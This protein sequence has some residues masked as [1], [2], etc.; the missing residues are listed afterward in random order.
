MRWSYNTIFFF[1]N[2]PQQTPHSSPVRTKYGV[3]VVNTNS[4]LCSASVTR[5]LYTI[6][7]W[8][9]PCY[10]G[11]RLYMKSHHIDQTI[12]KLTYFQNSECFTPK[13]KSTSIFWFIPCLLRLWKNGL[14]HLGNGMQVYSTVTIPMSIHD[15]C[16][17]WTPRRHDEVL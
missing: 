17:Q 5:V 8:I 11:T 9:R 6:S 16:K 3:S 14:R 15:I 7:C 2:S 1:T 10:K 4:D 12:V 13:C